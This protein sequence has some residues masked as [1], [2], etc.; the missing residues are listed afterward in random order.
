MNKL[1]KM[2]QAYKIKR[3][4]AKFVQCICKNNIVPFHVHYTN[5]VQK[6]V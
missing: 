4:H 6:G 2:Y 3:D 5:M 1:I